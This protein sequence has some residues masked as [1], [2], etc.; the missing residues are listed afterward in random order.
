MWAKVLAL[1][2][3]NFTCI[4]KA[5]VRKMGDE[6][7]TRKAHEPL[8]H[9]T[10][11]SPQRADFQEIMQAH[12]SAVRA[13]LSGYHDPK[14]GAFVFTV[15]TLLKRGSCCNSGCRHCPYVEQQ[16]TQASS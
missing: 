2:N 12:D 3:V 8:P 7:S 11:L 4:V 1:R 9:V 14:T 15:V 10:R 5:G 13:G 16:Q 6:L